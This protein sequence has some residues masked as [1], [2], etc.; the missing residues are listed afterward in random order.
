M[1]SKNNINKCEIGAFLAR[2]NEFPPFFVYYLARRRNWR[3]LGVEVN[4]RRPTK[5]ERPTIEEMSK[6]ADLPQRTF[7]RIASKL[8]WGEVKLKQIEPFLRACR[9][10][11]KNARK[12]KDYIR[13]TMDS[14][15]PFNHLKKSQR[16]KF[17]LQCSR[18]A[19]EIENA[20][21][22]S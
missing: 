13:H 12:L 4:D 16:K 17:D 20:A 1:N 19:L 7:L 5:A 8:N 3:Q 6:E 11:I 9:V 18:W 10:D 14:A 22:K 21:A 2:L 15:T